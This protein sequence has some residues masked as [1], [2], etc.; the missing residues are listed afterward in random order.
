[1]TDRLKTALAEIADRAPTAHVPDDTYRRGRRSHRR[2]VAAG[3]LALVVVC[4]GLGSVVRV[5]THEPP[6]VTRQPHGGAVPSQL[7]GVPQRLT[8]T[9]GQGRWAGPVE[10]DLA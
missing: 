2:R 10:T 8:M 7:Y 4:L 9:D 5:V 6:P 1:M 3:A